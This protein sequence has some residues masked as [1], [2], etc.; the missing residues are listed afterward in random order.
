M[1]QTLS[2]VW[3]RGSE[4]LIRVHLGSRLRKGLET[5][6]KAPPIRKTKKT[7]VTG[8]IRI[9]KQEKCLSMRSLKSSMKAIRRCCSKSSNSQPR[10]ASSLKSVVVPKTKSKNPSKLPC[11]VLYQCQ[12]SKIWSQNPA[13]KERLKAKN[14]SLHPSHCQ[15]MQEECRNRLNLK[16][17]SKKNSSPT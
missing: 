1:S 12:I 16:N 3:V 8:R 9:L 11:S 6:I 5:E 2:H 7:K 15:L 17:K 10:S 14:P 4:W 13:W